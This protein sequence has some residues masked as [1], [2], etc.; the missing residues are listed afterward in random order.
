MATSLGLAVVIWNLQKANPA[1]DLSLVYNL[2]LGGFTAFLGA[3]IALWVYSYLSFESQRREWR[4]DLEV[5]HF[6]QIYGPLFEDTKKIVDG[7]REYSQVWLTKWREIRKSS[8][9]PFVE[10]TISRAVSDLQEKVDKYGEV[11]NLSA[12]AAEARVRE[13]VA[14]HA[15]ATLLDKNDR[16]SLWAN[17]RDDPRFLFDPGKP[18]PYQHLV[19]QIAKLLPRTEGTDVTVQE[20]EKFLREVKTDLLEDPAIKK[21]IAE[22]QKLLP[23]AE[24]VHAL[25]DARMR[26]PFT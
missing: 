24:R 5:R 2:S 25:I 22:C 9:G 14:H 21:R 10:E 18:L 16:N 1:V 20:A 8:L 17:L 3:T 19:Q 4:H 7:L 6:E 23:E 15:R 11:T 26:D 13:F 12:T